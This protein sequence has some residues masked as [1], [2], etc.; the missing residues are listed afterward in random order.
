MKIVKVLERIYSDLIAEEVDYQYVPFSLEDIN[1]L[2]NQDE[3]RA[4]KFMLNTNQSY[5]T[6][7]GLAETV[8]SIREKKD[9]Y[10]L[11]RYC[12]LRN[13]CLSSCV[14]SIFEES[15]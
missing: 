12:V 7:M 5:K 14:N 15:L 13:R 11:L 8:K 10:L 4:L 6:E 2:N 1:V 9:Y 3:L